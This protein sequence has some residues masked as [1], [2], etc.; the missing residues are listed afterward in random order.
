VRVLAWSGRFR[1]I[2]AT[3]PATWKSTSE[4][5]GMSLPGL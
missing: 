5:E 2:R 4:L 3:A 1:A